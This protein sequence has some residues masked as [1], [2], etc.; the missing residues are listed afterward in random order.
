MIMKAPKILIVGNLVMN[1][2]YSTSEVQNEGEIVNDGLSFTSDQGEKD[3]NE[4]VQATR[5]DMDI[6]MFGKLG[7]DTVGDILLKAIQEAGINTDNILMDEDCSSVVSNIIL[8]AIPDKKNTLNLKA[9]V[10]NN[11]E[12]T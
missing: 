1:L 7:K 8:E 3:V 2:I 5:F 10:G 12:C 9:K 11:C 4:L 6:T